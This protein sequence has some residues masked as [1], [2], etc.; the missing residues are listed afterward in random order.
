MWREVPAEICVVRTFVGELAPQFV[1]LEEQVIAQRKV[2]QIKGPS[3]ATI[4][5][6]RLRGPSNSV[7]CNPYSYL[8]GG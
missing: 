6:S 1:V 3:H 8:D 7:A 4:W 2:V 5:F